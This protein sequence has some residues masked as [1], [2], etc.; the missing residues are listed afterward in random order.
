MPKISIEENIEDDLREKT[1]DDLEDLEEYDG[2]EMEA[3]GP[4]DDN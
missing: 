2:N 3:E 4:K 1:E